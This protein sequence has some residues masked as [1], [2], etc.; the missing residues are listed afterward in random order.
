M[1]K[2]TLP[3]PPDFDSPEE[4]KDII[5]FL[6][7]KLA[8][9]EDR[10]NQ[11]S[12]NSSVPS[13]QQPLHNKAKNTSPNRKKSG[14]KQGAQPGH[15]GHR[16]LLH[17]VEDS[18]S[19]EQY[20]PN[21]ICHCGGCVIPNRKPYKRHQI[22]DLPDISY[23]LVEHQIFK[24]EC[25]WCGDKHQA[26]LP[27]SVPDVQMGPN[28]HSFIAI[29]ATQH[30]QSIGKI[31]SMLKDVFQLNFST[32]AISA[33]QGRVTEYLADTHTQIHDTVK[34]SK[35]IMADET[36]HQRNND[37]RWMWAAL[38]N[39]VAFFQINS[40][41]N[42]HAAKRLLGEAVSHLLVT[43]QYS[44]YKYIDES[45]RQLCW[46]HILR[47][48]I[49]IEESVCPENQKIGEKLALIAHSVFRCHHRY[50]EE[51]IT[52]SQYYRR[53]RRLRKSWLHWLKLGSYQCSKRYR[54][55]CRNLI[56]DDA[57]VW[58]F[59]DDSEC[60]LTNNA[61]ERVL[62]NY[63]LMRKCCYV[64]RSYRGDQFRE[65]MFSLIETAKLQQVSAYKWL[66]EIVEHH[67]LKVDYQ[68]PVF[69]A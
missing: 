34:A 45:K 20:L 18:A 8:E 29:Q 43:D 25:A 28:L 5:H 21:K 38:S 1:N 41:R 46:A 26:E 33:A 37:K 4:A 7:N 32:G 52:E 54:G 58:R 40:G 39:D 67:M 60:P 49:A 47:N 19:V 42:Q 15:K 51:K 69:L 13:S 53:L 30:H 6:W 56:A 27:E 62:R 64:T 59:M 10:L 16:R 14:K 50:I 24:G 61:A 65:R 31:Q 66:R 2:K 63:I 23:T 48:V 3:P 17:P 36:S 35:L 68:A 57:M 44:A 9:L 12:R 55:R 11:N 22:F